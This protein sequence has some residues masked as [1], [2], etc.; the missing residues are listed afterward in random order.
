MFTEAFH[1]TVKGIHLALEVKTS[2]GNSTP[3]M[4]SVRDPVHRSLDFSLTAFNDFTE[5]DRRGGTCT[6][7]KYKA[8]LERLRSAR[9][10]R[11]DQAVRLL[12]MQRLKAI[13]TF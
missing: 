11:H 3:A 7:K 10:T 6:H 2:F 4:V 8:K 12:D 9:L 13:K 5:R 1:S